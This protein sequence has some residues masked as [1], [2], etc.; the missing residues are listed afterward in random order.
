MKLKTLSF[1]SVLILL[2]TGVGMA[3]SPCD[4]VTL[5]W[6]NAQ[7]HL[8]KDARIVHTAETLGICE[9]VL[10]MDGDLV[11]AYAG[12][13]WLLAGQMFSKGNSVTRETMESLSDVAEQERQLAK[14]KEALAEENANFFS[15]RTP[16]NWRIWSP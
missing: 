9:V 7:V 16:G 11:P 2:L 14:E 12:K 1:I 8:P 10:A 13:D 6:L 4:H 5:D 3:Q 15:R